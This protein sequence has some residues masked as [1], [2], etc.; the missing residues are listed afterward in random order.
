MVRHKWTAGAVLTTVPGGTVTGRTGMPPVKR[1]HVCL[2]MVLFVAAAVPVAIAAQRRR[3]A[4]VE[5]S[6]FREGLLSAGPVLLDPNPPAESN[7]RRGPHS[8]RAL[9]RG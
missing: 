9:S 2:G 8:E 4:R 6:S 5:A 1:A 7:Q 3:E